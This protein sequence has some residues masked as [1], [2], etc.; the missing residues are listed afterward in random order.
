[1]LSVAKKGTTN[2]NLGNQ[3]SRF[4]TWESKG[5]EQETNEEGKKVNRRDPETG[6]CIPKYIPRNPS[7]TTYWKAPQARAYNI[8]ATPSPEKFYLHHAITHELRDSHWWTSEE[9][10]YPLPLSLAKKTK[11]W[12]YNQSEEESENS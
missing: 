10:E 6:M 8:L 11:E 2:N 7:Q 1:M 12:S 3:M 4:D 9:C 5:Y